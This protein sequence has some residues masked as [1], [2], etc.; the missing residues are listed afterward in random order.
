MQ[1]P[2]LLLLLAS[3]SL[4]LPL[5]VQPSSS[6]TTTLHKR[7]VK[8]LSETEHA[9]KLAGV[10][11]LNGKHKR[12][13]QP[14]S[15]WVPLKDSAAASKAVNQPQKRQQELVGDTGLYAS[16]HR[17]PLK[18]GQA[19]SEQLVQR[20]VLDPRL[21]YVQHVNHALARRERYAGG[22]DLQ[23]RADLRDQLRA[24]AEERMRKRWIDIHQEEGLQAP[25]LK[26]GKRGRLVSAWSLAGSLKES[27]VGETHGLH[28][29]SYASQEGLLTNTNMFG[30]N[31]GMANDLAAVNSQ[32]SG[33]GAGFD[34][35]LLAIATAQSITEPENDGPAGSAGLSIQGN[36]IAIFAEMALGSQGTK[37]NILMDSGSADFWVPSEVCN[38]D[39]TCGGHQTLGATNSNTFQA[40]QQPWSIT[41]GACAAR[42]RS[43]EPA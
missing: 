7:Y 33:S 41:Y 30:V 34:P 4:A 8:K 35:T 12:S 10:R 17:V 15:G 11:L 38:D 13:V 42:L 36:N 22:R 24:E 27:G 40:T 26:L 2:F 1:L 23:K 14:S 5:D 20:G 31:R 29:H 37:F 32:A 43:S 18:R 21:Y 19:E 3:F 6:S 9:D 28:T 39:G 16:T 25:A